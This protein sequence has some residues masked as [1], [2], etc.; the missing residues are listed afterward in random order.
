MTKIKDEVIQFLVNY[1]FQIV[2]GLIIFICG[3]FI[4]GALGRLVKKSLTRFKLE[5]PVETLL[6]RV[7]KLIVI[8]LT[9]ILTVSK[10]GV[11]IAPLV[12]GVGVVGVGVGLATQG[13]LA[14]LVAGLLIIFAKP[15]RV[16]E[17]IDLLGEEGVVQRIDLFSTKLTHADKSIV[18]IPNRKIVGEVLHNYGTIRQLN[19][20]IGVTY[21]TNLRHV[22]QVVREVL[23]RSTKVLKDPAPAYG[24]VELADS[25]INIAIKPWVLVENFAGAPGELYQAIVEAFRDQRIDMPFPQREI[26]I[27]NLNDAANGALTP[28]QSRSA[29]G[30]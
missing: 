25:S 5:Q 28:L 22:E 14:N 27:L 7:T 15:F 4:A 21:D 26:R 13:V 17:F 6:V 24:V 19:L 23:A 20:S 3:V 9:G 18:V 8:L 16:G 11:D 29:T 2:G 30:I 12:A 10:M 1:G